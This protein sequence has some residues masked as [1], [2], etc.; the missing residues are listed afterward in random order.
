MPINS[1]WQ[2]ETMSQIAV[3]SRYSDQ[4]SPIEVTARRTPKSSRVDTAF[5][6][7]VDAANPLQ[8]IPGVAQV[9]RKT[10]GDKASLGAQLAG[11]VGI[12]AAIAGPIGA[13]AGAG[14][15]VLE[16]AVP[17][18]FNFIGKLFGSGKSSA[19]KAEMPQMVGEAKTSAQQSAPLIAGLDAR[20][21]SKTARTAPRAAPAIPQFSSDQFALLMGSFGAAVPDASKP[22]SGKDAVAA[23]MQ[24][25]LEKYR[26]QQQAIS[27]R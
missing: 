2:G 5:E 19:S 7:L 22:A 15:F 11:R 4:I 3:Q 9:Y 13:A 24:A 17:A 12:G 10:T 21:G 6:T 18:V 26:R 23:Q 25:N 20:P 8:Q 14:V 16:Q 1:A 27:A